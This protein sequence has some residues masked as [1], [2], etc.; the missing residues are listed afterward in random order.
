MNFFYRLLAWLLRP[1]LKLLFKGS[2]LE[3]KA[4]DETDRNITKAEEREKP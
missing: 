4:Q 3:S 1:F 2:A